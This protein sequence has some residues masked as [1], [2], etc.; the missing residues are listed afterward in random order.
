[1]S[2]FVDFEFED[3]T[4]ALVQITPV[5]GSD[6]DRPGDTQW[7]DDVPVGPVGAGS[8]VIQ[9]S[10]RML[11]DAFAPLAPLLSGI[12]ARAR[13]MPHAP[14]ELSIEFGVKLTAGLKM[15][16]VSGG[17]ASFTVTA[18]W[19]TTRA[20]GQTV[21]PEGA[22]QPGEPPTAAGEPQS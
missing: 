19:N 5:E 1:M 10:G 22:L 8:R 20:P 7:E 15:A 4:S 16:V 11:H 17:E 6:P 14:D 13:E 12:H 21:P 3:G 9:R 18:T 2:R